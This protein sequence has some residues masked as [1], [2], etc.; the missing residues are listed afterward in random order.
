MIYYLLY[1][2]T[3]Q[4]YILHYLYA[5]PINKYRIN[6]HQLIAIKETPAGVLFPLVMS[7]PVATPMA[8]CMLSRIRQTNSHV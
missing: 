8:E 1:V 4:L 5:I 6:H 7:C 3:P 2:H